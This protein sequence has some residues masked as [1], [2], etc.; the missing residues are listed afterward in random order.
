MSA[1][2]Y[3]LRVGGRVWLDGQGWEVVELVDGAVRLSS[4]RG[5]RTVTLSSLLDGV[6]ELD[7]ESTVVA[8]DRLWSIPAVI[9]AGLTAKQRDVLDKKLARL[10]RLL[11]PS[12]DDGRSLGQRYDD[13]A[14]ELR[15]SRRTLQR[16]VARLIQLGPAGLV[17][18][19]M[20]QQV[21]RTVDPRWDSACLQ[22]L[23]SYTTAST[24]TKQAVIRRANAEFGRV[25][26]DGMPPSPAVA[27]RRLDEL[28]RGR[29]MFGPA[30]QRR[31]VANRPTGV[32]GRLR[33]DR[34]GQYVLLDSY[35]L[36]V[37]AME[38]VA[39]RW[40]NTEVTVGMDL[41]DR[42][43]TGLRLRPLAARSPDV[44]SVLYQTVTPQRWAGPPGHR[45]ARTPGCRT[46]S[47]SAIPA[48][49]CPTPS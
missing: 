1:T 47:C 17:D 27:Y 30:K 35:R 28:A 37:F 29:Y 13:L 33:A 22:V 39:L 9:V 18:T 21:R 23:A 14:A 24:P 10:R 2:G 3:E 48:R 43:I 26:P 31:S 38:P 44:A 15:V 40:V 32:L 34:P 41:F 6:T 42:C 20:L 19:R 5:V 46:G 8:D 36:D 25:V 49:C 4:A 11:E 12:P 16:Q 7:D 45:P